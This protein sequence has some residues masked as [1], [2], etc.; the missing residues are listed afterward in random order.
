MVSMER[1]LQRVLVRKGALMILAALALLATGCAGSSEN[2]DE[3]AASPPPAVAPAVPPAQSEPEWIR[4]LVNRFLIDMNE[5]LRV[6]TSLGTDEVQLYLRTGNRQSIGVLRKRMTDLKE[7]SGKLRRVGPPPTESGPLVRVYENLQ[8]SCPHYERLARAV[9]ASIPLLGSGNADDTT[10]GE[11]ELE[12]AY[13]PSR[14]AARHYGAAVQIIEQ[15]GL[16][17]SYQG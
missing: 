7:C 3:D 11:A 5:N 4:R 8:R 9:L 12:K 15:N 6:V 13:A 16:L 14:E 1:R 2:D 17:S 10:K